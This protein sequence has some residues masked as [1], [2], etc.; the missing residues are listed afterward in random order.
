M[1]LSVCVQMLGLCVLTTSL[2]S[3]ERALE[4]DYVRSHWDRFDYRYSRA[5]NIEKMPLE[6][7]RIVGKNFSYY[8]GAQIG[9]AIKQRDYHK[10]Y[11]RSYGP[12]Q[13][14]ENP[15]PNYRWSQQDRDTYRYQ[16]YDVSTNPVSPGSNVY[17]KPGYAERARKGSPKTMFYRIFGPK[18]GVKPQENMKNDSTTVPVRTM[19]QKLS[20]WKKDGQNQGDSRS[21]VQRLPEV[22]G[23]KRGFKEGPVPKEESPSWVTLFD[24]RKQKDQFLEDRRK[25]LWS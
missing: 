20:F 15:P 1:K 24:N 19:W 4:Q 23:S 2:Y 16:Q 12:K 8:E 22:V 5:Y 9:A 11:E 17:S 13:W 7:S 21:N 3:V 14:K 6:R 25:P 10:K 18:D